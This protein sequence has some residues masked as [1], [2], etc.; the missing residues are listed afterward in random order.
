MAAYHDRVI[1]EAFEFLQTDGT[2]Q[3]MNIEHWDQFIQHYKNS[4]TVRIPVQFGHWKS[5]SAFYYVLESVGTKRMVFIKQLTS[6]PTRFGD[7]YGFFGFHTFR[8]YKMGRPIMVV[9]GIVDWWQARRIYPFV[10][11][12]FH[13]GLSQY[14][15]HILRS[16]T[17]K[18]I[19]GFDKDEAG[20]S[21]TRS[22]VLQAEELG[23]KT[24]VL[25]PAHKDFGDYAKDSDSEY[26]IERHKALLKK[27]VW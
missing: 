5:D 23:I 18:I 27:A 9:E 12:C 6:Q 2:K 10:L 1:S 7:C 15:W 4:G 20:A 19:V 22:V 25:T 8:R 24:K 26:L 3:P 17:R 13:V 14:Q 21:G 16:L 11:C